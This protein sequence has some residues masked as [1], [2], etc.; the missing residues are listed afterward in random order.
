MFSTYRTYLPYEHGGQRVDALS[1]ALAVTIERVISPFL[2]ALLFGNRFGVQGA[3][4][5][6]CVIGAERLASMPT[7]PRRVSLTDVIARPLL[8]IMWR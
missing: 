8:V 3:W 6:A 7:L 5:S 2:A 4:G 1:A